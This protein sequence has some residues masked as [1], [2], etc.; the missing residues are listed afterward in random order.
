MD[1]KLHT[2]DDCPPRDVFDALA[3][4][5]M[6]V[7]GTA[8]GTLRGTLLGTAT[9]GRRYGFDLVLDVDGAARTFDAEE[10]AA[11]DLLWS[12]VPVQFAREVL[13]VAK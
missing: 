13:G 2:S 3:G 10:V 9:L 8:G 4:F 5:D 11:L 6:I 12:P 7:T 1:I